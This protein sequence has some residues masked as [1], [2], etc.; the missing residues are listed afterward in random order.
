MTIEFDLMQTGEIVGIRDGAGNWCQG[1]VT[2]KIASL[3]IE[4]FGVLIPFAHRTRASGRKWMA[5]SSVRVIGH[6]PP[7]E[8]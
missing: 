2:V 5:I 7:L 3:E 6:Q 1:P 4:A 8:A